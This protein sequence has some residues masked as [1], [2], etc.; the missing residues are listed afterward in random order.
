MEA[1]EGIAALVGEW[2]GTNK[3]ILEPGAP[4]AESAA[5]ASVSVA[6]T[7][8]SA[9][10]RYTWAEGKKP[11]DGVL[12]LRLGAEPGDWDLVWTDSFHMNQGFMACRP[13]ATKGGALSALGSYPAPPGPD[14][15]WRIEL[16]S[17][18][19]DEM[20][21]LMF[22]ITPGGEE[23][24]AVEADFTRAAIPQPAPA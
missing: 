24:L 6:G 14:W 21:L 22:N 18:A 17:P 20:Q 15:G 16:H 7:G 4:A 9:V 23:S 13:D 5:T 12:V 11:Q 1:R 10:V 19:E 2:R 8:S 3:L